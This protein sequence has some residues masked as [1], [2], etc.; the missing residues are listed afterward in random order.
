MQYYYHG[1]ELRQDDLGNLNFGYAG[2][3]LF[4]E[5]IL[6]AGAGANQIDNY[7][8]IL[9]FQRFCDKKWECFMNYREDAEKT[10]GF[11]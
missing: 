11:K 2:A 1:N 5:I 10:K 4:P 3:V 7:Q 9:N 6:C 8:N